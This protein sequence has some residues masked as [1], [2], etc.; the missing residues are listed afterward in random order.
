EPGGGALA[1]L[2]LVP[3]PRRARPAGAGAARGLRGQRAVAPVFYLGRD[4][5]RLEPDD[6][7]LLPVAG[8][9]ALAGGGA[10][11]S[12]LASP[13]A[14]RLDDRLPGAHVAAVRGAHAGDA[15]QRLSLITATG[16]PR[17]GAPRERPRR[18]AGASA[19]GASAGSSYS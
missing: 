10:R 2:G 6:R 8:A 4:R 9:V 14:P 13:P 3:S 1:V 16:S 18:R 17:R 7:E 11:A 12:A 19:R 5:L 15:R